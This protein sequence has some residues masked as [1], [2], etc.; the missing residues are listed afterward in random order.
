MTTYT[1]E[2]RV[3]MKMFQRMRNVGPAT[4]GDFIRLG[5]RTMDDLAKQDPDEMYAR[6]QEIDGIPHDPCV[7]DVFSASVAIARGEE[8]RDW[9]EFSR[10]RKARSTAVKA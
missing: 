10:E 5:L 1:A 3:V 6:I 4:A 7:H 8:P 2:D 9:W